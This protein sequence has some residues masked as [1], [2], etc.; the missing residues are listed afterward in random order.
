MNY[1]EAIKTFYNFQGDRFGK[2]KPGDYWNYVRDFLAEEVKL[3]LNNLK[4]KNILDLGSGPGRDSLLFKELGFKP[5]S[6]DI[7]WQMAK[8][9]HEKGL[10][11]CIMDAEKLAFKNNSLNGIWA[12]TS[13]LFM[14]KANLPKTL[15]K[16]SDV[17]ASEG[18]LFL[19]MK[20][21]DGEGYAHIHNE[22]EIPRYAALYRNEELREILAEDFDVLHF[23]SVKP[24][25]NNVYLNYLC[26]KK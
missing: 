12:Y 8:A 3:F 6:A 23:S 7:S 16:I 9:C 13:L 1:K 5:I 11:S 18:L 20:E 19:G 15:N 24:D 17:L 4:G 22:W 25:E 2:D 21:G 10:V 14:P 26:R